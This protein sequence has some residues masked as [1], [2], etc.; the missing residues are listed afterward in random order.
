MPHP[1]QELIGRLAGLDSNLVSDIM[2]AGGLRQ[3]AL[4]HTLRPIGSRAR[5]VG[6]VLC[7][8]GEPT[9]VASGRPALA[10]FAIDAALFPGC[11]V[12]I[13]NGGAP[14]CSLIG[15]LMARSWQTAGA[16]GLV[17]DGLVRDS[18]ELAEI[19]FPVFAAGTTPVASGGRWSLVEVGV[20]IHLP[21]CDGRPV[22]IAD[23]DLI[24]GD[25]DGCTVLPGP[26]AAEIISAA[27]K[28]KEIEARIIA[29]MANG[30]SRQEAFAAHPR[31]GHV[32]RFDH[33]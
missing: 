13:E 6:I 16:I 26:H 22:A 15:G 14:G 1:Q 2:D 25:A 20:P 5:I 33:G 18:P 24:I 28:L 9:S 21:G 32:P 8:R 29:M 31:F 19:G 30:K 27:E 3:Q 4:H 10:A 17:T 23:G 11:V 12:V 7:A